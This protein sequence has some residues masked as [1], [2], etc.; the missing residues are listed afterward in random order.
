M[1]VCEWKHRARFQNSKS[2]WFDLI[3]FDLFEWTK[4]V[5]RILKCNQRRILNGHIAMIVKFYG[6]FIADFIRRICA[7]F[8]I[9]LFL[10][11]SSA[12]TQSNKSIRTYS[13]LIDPSNCIKV[14]FFCVCMCVW[15][16]GQSVLNRVR[17][18]VSIFYLYTKCCALY[19]KTA[20]WLWL[21]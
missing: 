16:D 2:I 8:A 19:N 9:S 11:P 7:M 13:F 3:W 15:C 5:Q 12:V 18:C 17:T 14:N 4:T 21:Y 20:Y 10:F 6:I 1:C